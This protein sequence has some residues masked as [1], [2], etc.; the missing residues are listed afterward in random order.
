MVE[1]MNKDIEECGFHIIRNLLDERYMHDIVIRAES[2]YEK[3]C[4]MAHS[5]IMWEIRTRPEIRKVFEELYS[6]ENLITSFDGMTKKNKYGE[7][8]VLDC[9]VDQTV[10]NAKCVQG[11]LALRSSNSSTGSLVLYSGSHKIHKNLLD[12]YG[13]ESFE[14]NAWQFMSVEQEMVK[15]YKVVQPDLEPGDFILWDSKLVHSVAPATIKET[16]RLVA[17]ICMVPRIFASDATLKKR[18]R[19]FLRGSSS[20]HWPHM[21]VV[22]RSQN[23]HPQKWDKTPQCIRDLV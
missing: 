15:E 4:H 1:S 19:A 23:P 9:H 10:S 2:E 18:R 20:T 6:N 12:L 11:M 8:L 16:Q 3:C 7:G 5:D 22:R 14:E 13:C 21:F 17:Y